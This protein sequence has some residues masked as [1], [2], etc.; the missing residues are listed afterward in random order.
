MRR[1]A[2]RLLMIT[3]E[4]PT[5]ELLT[6]VDAALRGTGPEAD[7]LL[8]L[9]SAADGVLM[10]AA[11]R[12]RD[13]TRRR[14][15]R[16]LISRRADVAALANADGVQLPESALG[17]AEA[18]RLLPDGALIGCSRHDSAGLADAASQGADYATLSP[19]FEVPGKGPALGLARFAELVSAARLPV[20]ALG[21]LHAE[22][23]PATLAAGA[24]GV[25][26]TRALLG[27]SDPETAGRGLRREARL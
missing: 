18:R 13:V 4:L 17:V 16:L 14:G 10:D 19:I 23:I 26:I 24:F 12:L 2:P 3:P 6:R 25:A 20:L 1:A 15:A 22:R 11:L 27:A 9:P 5:A 21:G 8:R 7:V